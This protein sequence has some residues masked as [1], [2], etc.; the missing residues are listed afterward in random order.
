MR[1]RAGADVRRELICAAAAFTLCWLFLY[2]FARFIFAGIHTLQRAGQELV[3][4]YVSVEKSTPLDRPSTGRPSAE[5]TPARRP[6]EASRT[7][8]EFVSQ[9]R[10]NR[11]EYAGDRALM[12]T[13]GR[14]QLKDEPRRWELE[15][16]S[17]K[18]DP[19]AE[20]AP[21]DLP[22]TEGVNAPKSPPSTSKKITFTPRPAIQAE[23]EFIS[24]TGAPS[25]PIEGSP[26]GQ[27]SRSA[28]GVLYNELPELPEWF[29]KKGI[30]SVLWLNLTV[31]SD[32]H[33]ESAQIY[34]TCGFKELDAKYREAVMKWKFDPGEARE[35]WVLKLNFTLQ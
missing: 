17:D 15:K 29:E 10:L 31:G 34:R 21:V 13:H 5:A 18:P 28:R 22:L 30:D 20:P 27:S 6:A 4:Q 19:R 16:P 23:M 25:R 14:A 35:S 24:L 12:L 11:P 7:R 32:G 33:V 8:Q 26:E 3:V 2:I 9:A 1:P